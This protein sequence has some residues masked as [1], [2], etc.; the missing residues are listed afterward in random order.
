MQQLAPDNLVPKIKSLL[1]NKVSNVAILAIVILVEQRM[2]KVSLY[3]FIWTL[4]NSP[5]SVTWQ[6][7]YYTAALGICG[8]AE[9][10]MGCLHHSLSSFKWDA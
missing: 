9:F 3:F 2:G 5:L 8:D 10:W 1:S 6:I 4:T 7:A